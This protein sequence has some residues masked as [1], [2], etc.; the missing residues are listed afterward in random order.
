VRVPVSAAAVPAR[1]PTRRPHPPS[2]RWTGAAAA[3][4]LTVALGGSPTTTHAQPAPATLPAEVLAALRDAKVPP[5]ALSVLVQDAAGAAPPRLAWR[6]RQPVNPASLFKLLTTAAALDLLGPAH[7][8]TTPVWVQGPVEGGVLRGDLV[9]KGQG[10]PKLVLERVWSLL[11]RVRAQGVQEIRGDIV[12]DRSAFAPEDG[13]PADFDGE[14]LRPYNVRANALL[15]NQRSLLL[16]LIPQPGAGVA[17]VQAEPPLADVQVDASVPLASGPC[18]DWR[19]ALQL[20]WADPHR[21]RL[22]GRYPVACGERQWPLAPP[23]PAAYDG[24][25][26]RALWRELGGSLTGTVRDGAAPTTTPSFVVTSPS[27]AE[28]VRDVNKFSNNPMAQQVFLSLALPPADATGVVAGAPATSA[29][30][31]ERL[32][33]WLAQRLGAELAQEVVVDNGSGLSREQRV[34]AALL[35]RLLQWAWASPVMPELM[36][37]LPVAGLDGTARRSRGAVGRAHLKTGSLRD[38]AAVAGYVLTRGG[39][40]QVLV[41]VVQHP[42]ANA[43]RPALE[44]LL[45]WTLQ[46]EARAAR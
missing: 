32:R 24:R 5:E 37:S 45:Q 26:L 27:L 38:V 14:G 35:G 19:G 12:L 21:L 34:S 46:D 43:A 9:I 40:R 22:A 31:R 33:Q 29:A 23:D 36:A 3:L 17:L 13:S 42:N 28:V 25:L 20:Q 11:R 1:H 16:G 4:L 44:A 30:A 10:D 6:T 8:W 2:P 18:D 39:Q 15:L 41:A 7:A